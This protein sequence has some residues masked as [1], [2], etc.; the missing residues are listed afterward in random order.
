[1]PDWWQA[2]SSIHR[3]K[4]PSRPVFVIADVFPTSVAD[5]MLLQLAPEKNVW[6]DVNVVKNSVIKFYDIW[7]TTLIYYHELDE[8]NFN[9]NRWRLS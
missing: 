4:N 6:Q 8:F 7:E 3:S 2:T 9:S 1:M 5:A